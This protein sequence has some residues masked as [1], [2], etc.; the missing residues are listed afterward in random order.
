LIRVPASSACLS[1]LALGSVVA[2][3]AIVAGAIGGVKYQ[4]RR[5][6]HLE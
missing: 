4:A 1:T 3:G 5:V 6:E 2:F